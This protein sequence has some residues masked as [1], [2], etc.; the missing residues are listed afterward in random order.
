VNQRWRRIAI[1]AAFLARSLPAETIS[2]RVLEDHSGAPL[3]SADVRVFRV[4]AHEAAAD[5]ET[6]AAGRFGASDLPPGEYRVEV[7]K[8]NYIGA[9]TLVRAGGS[10]LV[11]LVRCGVMAGQIGDQ[12]GQPVTGAHVFAMPFGGASV[13]AHAEADEKGKYRLNNLPPG[14]YAVAVTYGASTM[15]VGSS[16]SAAVLPEVGSGVLFYPDNTQP[17]PFTVAGGEEYRN[18]D[19]AVTPGALSSVSGKVDKASA[20]GR[21]WLALTPIG[22]PALAA[23]V[24]Q[25]EPDGSFHFEGI[26]VG[27]YNLFAAGPANARSTQGAILGP[28]PLFARVRVDISGQTIEGL[29]PGV[30]SGRSVDFALRAA[31]A[32]GSKT[33]PASAQVRLTSLEDWAVAFEYAAEVGPQGTRIDRLAPARYRIDVENLGDRCYAAASQILDLTRERGSEPVEVLVTPAGEIRG[34]LTGAAAD[35]GYA[36][37]LL[38]SAPGTDDAIRVAFP[39]HEFRFG[40]AGLRPGPY[41]I[42]AHDTGEDAKVRWVPNL[43]QM[44]EI[45]VPGGV[46][47]DVELPAPR[48]EKP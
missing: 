10:P 48:L 30:E 39:D 36:V 43:A 27:S 32:G 45:R 17:R 6:D 23:A 22:Q 4:G 40:F 5:L 16:G 13:T 47:T 24:T 31:H 37:V 11:R 3:A 8:R 28:E 46:P 2:G 21:F 33:C 42:A 19:F 12:H 25:A 18:V 26:P 38:P 9:T 14:R 1:F 44:I 20:N 35:V 29:S 41:R 34:L 15:A 7:S